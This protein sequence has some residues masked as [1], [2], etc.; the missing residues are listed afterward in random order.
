MA[1]DPLQLANLQEKYG[2]KSGESETE[3][4]W[5]VSGE[6][7]I[8]LNGTQAKGPWGPEVLLNLEPELA[9][10][11]YSIT[12]EA[13]YWAG[14]INATRRGDTASIPTRSSNEISAAV[15]KAAFM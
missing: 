5:R 15:T 9:N 14:A 1:W 10:Q 3:Y 4:L 12:S 6:A 2:R 13:A 7:R 11:P 8:S